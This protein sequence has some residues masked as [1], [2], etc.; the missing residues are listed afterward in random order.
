MEVLIIAGIILV[1]FMALGLILTKLYKRSTKEISFVR[2][3]FGGQK[4]VMDGGALVLPILHEVIPVNMN[5]LRLEVR[6]DSE[7]ALITKDRMR[8]DVSAEFYVRCSPNE[9]AIAVSAQTLGMKTMNPSQLKELIE[10]KFVDALRA[11]AAEMELMELHEQRI[12]FVQKVQTVVSEDLTKNGLELESVSLT[13][14]D[15]TSKEFFNPDNAFDAEGLTKLTE[16]I[17]SRKKQRNAIE[18]DTDVAISQKNLEAQQKKLQIQKEEEYARLEKEREVEIR[19]S[20]QKREIA[21]QQAE[22]ESAIATEKAE[23][24]REAEQSQINARQQVETSRIISERA[25]EEERIDKEKLLKERDIAKAK[26]VETAEID[27][28]RSVELAEQDKA[29]AIAEKSKDQSAA[30]AEAEKARALAVQEEEK[31]TT[32]RQTEIAEREKGVELVEAAKIAEKNAIGIKVSA[33][34]EKQ[35]AVDKAEAVMTTAKA[36]ADADMLQIEVKER[37]Y[38]IE[39]AGKLALNDA[40][41]ILSNDQIS[42]Q[43]KLAVVDQLP[44]IIRESVKPM[45]NID[46]IKII[47]VDGL[48]GGS[49]VSHSDDGVENSGGKGSLAD[50]VV[51][52]A[53]RYK[54]QAPLIESILSEVGLKGGDLN[55]LTQGLMGDPK[56]TNTE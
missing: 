24:E 31:V 18:Q 43:I 33:E 22:Q 56:E 30:K 21:V 53:L 52:S 6:R 32:V 3:G 38:E 12:N 13:G 49:S 11:V 8:V 17:E 55:S 47:N 37:D 23:R 42:M 10:G 50:Q 48:R 36:T 19:T 39:A 25:I 35:A 1:A 34:A 28:R 41:N 16:E 5:T 40:A 27:Q 26:A 45:E 7:Q 20:L 29:I 2:T 54:A 9:Q 4:V 15:Q 46:G 51:N 44:E 14:L